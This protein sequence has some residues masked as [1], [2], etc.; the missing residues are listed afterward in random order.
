MAALSSFSWGVCRHMAGLIVFCY[1]FLIRIEHVSF[2]HVR[3]SLTQDCFLRKMLV[4]L[5]RPSSRRP[6]LYFIVHLC[7]IITSE[8]ALCSWFD[9]QPYFIFSYQ[10][11]LKKEVTDK[12]VACRSRRVIETSRSFHSYEFYSIN[13]PGRRVETRFHLDWMTAY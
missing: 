10:H 2:C 9:L 5:H 1:Y 7:L 3:Y 13:I 12:R 6:F 11:H 8:S 4:N